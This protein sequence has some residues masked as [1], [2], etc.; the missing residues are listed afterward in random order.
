MK[1]DLIYDDIN[2][3]KVLRECPSNIVKIGYWRTFWHFGNHVSY[4]KYIYSFREEIIEA[5]IL[6]INILLSILFFPVI[7]FTNS[8]FLW[9]GSKREVDLENK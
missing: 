6:L 8:F 2:G 9:R 4:A 7:P 3:K 5:A 1:D